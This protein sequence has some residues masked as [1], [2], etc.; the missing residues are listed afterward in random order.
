MKE[1]NNKIEELKKKAGLS[2]NQETRPT[3]DVP[4]F[5]LHGTKGHMNIEKQK[6][7]DDWTKSK[8][9]DGHVEIIV[10]KER[11][12]FLKYNR[13]DK[14]TLWSTEYNNNNDMIRLFKSEGGESKLFDEGTPP[15]LRE[16][17]GLTGATNYILYGLV[18]GEVGK[19]IVKGSGLEEWFN[20]KD[21]LESK[22]IPLFLAVT[23]ASPEKVE[24][25]SVDYYKLTFNEIN[26]VDDET[27]ELVD[28]K[29]DEI[30]ENIAK[31]DAFVQ[32]RIQES[33]KSQ[34][35]TDDYEDVVSEMDDTEDIPF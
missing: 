7:D 32:E 12:K 33:I 6:N 25:G 8:L 19:L 27:L 23:V 16:R 2:G 34:P 9:K 3:Y 28:E 15:N 22:D 1:N 31:I 18:D 11:R 35:E 4:S 10:L 5:S 24:G 13:S 21:E 17:H 26:E 20:Y 29:M 14:T 30:N